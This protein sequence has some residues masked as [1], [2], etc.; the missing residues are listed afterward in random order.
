[1]A[2]VALTLEG[3]RELHVIDHLNP[4]FSEPLPEIERDIP[5]K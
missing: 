1:M 3:T 4:Y 5:A 2:G